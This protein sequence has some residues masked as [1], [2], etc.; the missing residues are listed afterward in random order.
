MKMKDEIKKLIVSNIKQWNDENIYAISLYVYDDEDNP[1]K[2]T[3][4]L[5]YNTEE[6]VQREKDNAWNEQEARWNYA[7][8]LQNEFFCF[9]IDNTAEIVKHWLKINNLPFYDD[10]D[11]AWEIDETYDE[12]EKITE[13]F[14]NELIEI[15]KE[16]HSEGILTDTFG[17]EIPI[18]IHE[19]EYYDEIA[20]Q[21][22]QAN[23]KELVKDFVNYCG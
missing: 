12:T 10:D 21:N 2:P 9:G 8:W 1:C 23:G 17:K 5:G 20:E 6:Q 7:F 18:L 15:V 13:L 14:V 3:V 16:I 4:T 22:I 11:D 19:L